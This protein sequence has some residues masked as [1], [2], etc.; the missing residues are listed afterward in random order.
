M[1]AW[2]PHMTAMTK[3]NKFRKPQG[4]P[5]KQQILEF[6][7]TS[8]TPAGKREIAKAFGLKGQEKIALKKRLKDMAEEGMIDGKKTAFHRMGG[9]PKVT[10]LRVVEETGFPAHRLQFEITENLVIQNAAEAFSQL[11]ELKSHAIGISIDDFGTGYSNLGYLAELPFTK[12]KLDR[13]LVSRLGERDNGTALVATIVNMAHAL[14]VSVL[15]EGV[16]TEE[17]VA[18]LQAAGCKLMQGYYFGKPVWLE[19]AQDKAA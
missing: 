9:L 5:S 14:N 17:Q 16:E 1:G 2:R 4:L 12:L 8:D 15:G 7:Q 18:L 13:S 10:V 3:Q 6:I 19:R 11:E